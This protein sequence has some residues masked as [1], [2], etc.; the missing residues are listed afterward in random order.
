M[1]MIDD[2]PGYRPG[3]CNI[4]PTEIAARRRVGHLGALATIGLGVALIWLGAP[5]WTRASL[6][7]PAAL[8]ASGYL[9]AALRFCAAFGWAGVVNFSDRIRDTISVAEAEARAKDRR[10]AIQIAGMSG[11]IGVGVAIAAIVL[12]V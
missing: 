2:A 9:Q 6:A 4:G 12:P 3:A 7:L 10:R 5:V 1:V 8:A 11:A